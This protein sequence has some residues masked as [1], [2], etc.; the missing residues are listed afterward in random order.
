[1]TKN[2]IVKTSVLIANI[3][4][5]MSGETI[6]LSNITINK[7]KLILR[8]HVAK[9]NIMFVSHSTFSYHL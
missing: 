3:N 7:E 8:C 1:M 5:K 9:L 2:F 4:L 6:K